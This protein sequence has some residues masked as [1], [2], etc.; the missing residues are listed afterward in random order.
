MSSGHIRTLPFCRSKVR[1]GAFLIEGPAP[2]ED[3]PNLQPNLRTGATRK[4]GIT[5]CLLVIVS[6]RVVNWPKT[7]EVPSE[8]EFLIGL[9]CDLVQ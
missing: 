2:L 3:F 4:G 8:V 5:S 6:V 9:P 1:S 7:V